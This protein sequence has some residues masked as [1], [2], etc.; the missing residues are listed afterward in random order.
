[1]AGDN[2]DEAC[3]ALLAFATAPDGASDAEKEEGNAGGDKAHSRKNRTKPDSAPEKGGSGGR[4]RR[5]DH[6]D[7]EYTEG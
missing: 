4:K 6:D 5:R 7:A 3:A 2:D 1:M